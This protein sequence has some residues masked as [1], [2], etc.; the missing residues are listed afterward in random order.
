[1]ENSGGSLKNEGNN[2]GTQVGVNTGVINIDMTPKKT[3]SILSKV[4]QKILDIPK[5]VDQ[6]IS[7]RKLIPYDIIDKINHNFVIKYNQI[8]AKYKAYYYICDK[9]INIIDSNGNLSEKLTFLNYLND[10]YIETIGEYLREEIFKTGEL[11]K[12]IEIIQKNLIADKIIEKIYEKLNN[13]LQNEDLKEEEKKFGINILL[14]YGFIECK[15]LEE[16]CEKKEIEN[17]N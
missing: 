16:P 10:L 5:D 2:S 8:F 3:T 4:I 13:I 11:K 17:D 15:I 1:M 14:C 7:N 9:V 12:N 6:N